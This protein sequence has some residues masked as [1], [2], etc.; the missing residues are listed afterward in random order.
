MLRRNTEKGTGV[1]PYWVTCKCVYGHWM[2]EVMTVI[3]KSAILHCIDLY[4]DKNPLH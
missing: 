2:Y 1:G 4:G 3:I